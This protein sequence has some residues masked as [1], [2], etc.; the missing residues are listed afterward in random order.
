MPWKT[1]AYWGENA[2]LNA[3]DNTLKLV[4]SLDDRTGV[5]MDIFHSELGRTTFEFLDKLRD[6]IV[7]I[8]L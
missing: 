2:F 6:R 5:D 7:S 8:H 4:S 3:T 1:I